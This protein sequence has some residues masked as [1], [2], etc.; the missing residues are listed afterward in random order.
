[1]NGIPVTSLDRTL[2]DIASML[3]PERLRYAVEAADRQ[4]RLDV[5][6][7]VTLCDASSGKR[8][9]G[10]LR[11]FAL[12]QRGPLNRTK[13]PPEALFLRG[14]RLRGMPEPLVNVRLHG[15]EVD[16]L[17]PDAGLVVE[18]DSYTY[19]RSWP[20]R[21]R[22]IRRD[23]DLKV[24]GYDVV[25]FA[26]DRLAAEVDTVLVQVETLLGVPAATDL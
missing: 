8:G 10:N 26:A 20:Q 25:R 3:P 9:V 7:L 11:R 5:P 6:A 4:G 16:F 12:E 21:Q 17:W 24:H 15:Y 18:I 13:S 2:I 1:M 14:C 22:D 23:A 19:H